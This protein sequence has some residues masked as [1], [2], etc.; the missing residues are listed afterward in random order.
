MHACVLLLAGLIAS[1]QV[2]APAASAE[3]ASAPAA[4][5]RV[6]FW[7]W[8][9]DYYRAVVIYNAENPVESDEGLKAIQAK[10]EDK[11]R[12]LNLSLRKIDVTDKANIDEKTT[13]VLKIAEPEKFPF[14]IIY[15]PE[16]S[17]VENPLWTGHVT[18]EEA[19]TVADSPARRE[20]ARRL[21]KGESAVWLLIESGVEYK[22]YRILKLLSEEIKNIGSNPSGGETPVPPKT[23][24]AK[25]ENKPGKHV[26]MSIMRI[27]R[28]D[29]AEKSLLNM[30]N[31]IEPEIMNV[32]NEP[33]LVPVYARGRVLELFPNDEIN[34]DNIRNT[35]GLLA[36]ENIDRETGL[37]TGTALLLSVNWDGFTDR[38][39]SIDEELPALRDYSDNFSLDDI[40]PSE[41]LSAPDSASTADKEQTVAAKPPFS[42]RIINII[43]IS[44][45]GSLILLSLAIA[46][47][48][49]K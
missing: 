21:L 26:K 36:G 31:F 42:M 3:P 5:S 1:A 16:N 32:S 6:G 29:T 35:I 46:L 11:T 27:S 12:S 24:G 7:K 49:R 43:L 40:F 38:K 30:L 19:D 44:I 37:K 41:N 13:E 22:D 15:F 8:K 48:S 45:I 4:A 23:D 39:L 33:V 25:E 47:R 14:T 18:L 34:R 20:I 17:D 28:D 9:P 10:T 2:S